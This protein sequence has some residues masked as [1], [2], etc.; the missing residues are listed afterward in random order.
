MAGKKNEENRKIGKDTLFEVLRD[1][2][3][4]FKDIKL[5]YIPRPAYLKQL[6][7][8]ITSKSIIAIKGARRAGKT[9][10]LKLLIQNLTKEKI[11]KEQILYVN[12]EDY[13]LYPYYSL[14]LLEKILETYK[15][16]INPD[17]KVFFFIDEIQ[18]IKGFEHFLRTLY[19]QEENIK[20]VIT[21]SNSKLLSKELGTLLTGRIST[22]EVFP[23]S[24]EEFLKFNNITIGKK[25]YF[26][27]EQ[28]KGI[29]K[30]QFNKYLKFGAIPEFLKDKEPFFRLREYLDN[31]LFKDI[32]ERFNIRNVK[33]IK[34]LSLYLITN[35]SKIFS[36][37]Q[38]SRIFKV[39]INTIQE[40]LFNLNMAYL[41][42]YLDKFSFSAKERIT[43]QSK[44]YC[45]DTGL[46]NSTGFK[47]SRD[48][49]RLLENI[50][51]LELIRNN[52]EI[53]Y[54]SN[55][56][57]ECDFVIKENLKVTGAV[58]VTKSLED[59]K[60][61]EREIQGLVKALEEFRLSKGFILTEDE[62][63]DINHKGLKILVRPIWFWLLNK[64]E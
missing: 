31:I 49:G 18:N 28:K 51:F 19:D 12:L 24:F 21:G 37:N 36:I 39:S 41:F 25:T 44:V 33:L 54:Y 14:E 56:G 10:L 46:I 63:K 9:V 60:T 17:K 34:E 50:V 40:Y 47:F 55:S 48:H 35:S 45:I 15:E 62:F 22:I 59:E 7:R 32:V 23:F 1:Q 52:K 57:K 43:T 16:N 27:L 42:F 58:Q 8:L 26:N 6:G 38:L 29:I 2:N 11:S 30:K 4:W 64:E 13:R 61:K 53:Y 20:L 3:Y 5:D